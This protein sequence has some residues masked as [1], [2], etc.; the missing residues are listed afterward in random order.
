MSRGDAASPLLPLRKS[1]ASSP[2]KRTILEGAVRLFRERGYHGTSIRDIG[3][4]AG[5]TSAALYRHFANKDA[6]LETALW[7]F[8]R[9]VAASSR[10]A[11]G[12]EDQSPRE[13]LQA[14]VYTFAEV[15][16]EERNFLAAYLFEARNLRPA[17][18][19][20]MQRSERE[21]RDQWMHHL[22]V[23]RPEL[24]ETGA[25]AMVRAALLMVAHGCLEDPEVD[26]GRLADLLTDMATTA[27]LGSELE[28]QGS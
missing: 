22:R 2:R 23:A 1:P 3:A 8:A 5:V 11:V 28:L 16:L 18:F 10:N 24:S 20:E 13:S 21:Y 6:V 25:R 7:E 9:H 17:V 19:T 4:A 12:Q 14:L 26:A 27:M 15:A